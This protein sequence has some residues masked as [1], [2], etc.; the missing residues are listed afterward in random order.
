MSYAVEVA[1]ATY[2][3]AANERDADERA[4]LLEACFAKDVRLVSP[5]REIRGR[6]A[7]S[8]EI[9]RLLA[10]PAVVAVRLD[11]IVDAGVTTFRFRSRVERR[12]GKSQVFVDAGE[13]DATGRIAL[14]L[15]FAGDLPAPDAR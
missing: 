9:A 11:G 3:R 15:T 12:D 13:V 10:D 6:D 4:S 14:I 1:V 2:V 8:R 5:S 7:L